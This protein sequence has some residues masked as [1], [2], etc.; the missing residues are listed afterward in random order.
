M[1][2]IFVNEHCLI[3]EVEHSSQ[4][5]NQIGCDPNPEKCLGAHFQWNADRKIQE[6]KTH[7]FVGVCWLNKNKSFIC[8]SPK[9]SKLHYLQ[10]FLTCLSDPIVAKHFNKTYKIFFNE[11]LIEVEKSLKKIDI[12]LLL[13]VHFLSVVKRISQKGLKKGYITVN[14]NLTGKI[15][16]KIKIQQNICKN[17]SLNRADRN[18]CQYQ[19]HTQNCLENRL[20]KTA[21]QQVSRYLYRHIVKHQNN[22]E[23]F[24]LLKFNQFSFESISEI[25]VSLN[26]FKMINHSAFYAEYKDAL[27]LAEMI[28]KEIRV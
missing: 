18:V 20:I 2:G 9:N 6:I 26:D 12:T 22:E 10:L 1:K 4:L 24:K 3:D 5:S 23:L 15:K 7:Y 19:M 25:K 21:I 14:E 28:F 11:P 13:I 16:G 8:V 17:L 27:R